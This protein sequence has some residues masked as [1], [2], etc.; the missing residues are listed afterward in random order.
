MRVWSW[1]E[2]DSERL[3]STPQPSAHNQ[4]V[5]RLESREHTNVPRQL[6]RRVLK[7][8]GEAMNH[9]KAVYEPRY[10]DLQWMKGVLEITKEGAVI[11]YPSTGLIFN[12][13]HENRTLTLTN[14]EKLS[15]RDC[16][17]VYERTI[18]VAGF[19]DYTVEEKTMDATG[20][21]FAKGLNE[22][23]QVFGLSLTERK[24]IETYLSARLKGQKPQDVCRKIASNRKKRHQKAVCPVRLTFN[25]TNLLQQA[26]TLREAVA[27]V[28]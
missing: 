16:Q 25:V 24:A 6:G 7:P 20:G 2:D 3:T 18:P 1:H 8:K 28:A 21:M 10:I 4:L 19:F 27:H 12:V 23:E 26:Q 5:R 15:D 9:E 14:P 13:S 17:D 22:L 11:V